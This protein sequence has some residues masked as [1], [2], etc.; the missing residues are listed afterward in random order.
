MPRLIISLPPIPI[1][2]INVLYFATLKNNY[3]TTSNKFICQKLIE[4]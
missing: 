3:L 2:S 4:T 1:I